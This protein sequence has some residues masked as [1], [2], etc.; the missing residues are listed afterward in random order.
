MTTIR[1]IL[2]VEDSDFLRDALFLSL[3]NAGYQV[4]LAKD[5]EEGVGMARP[6]YDVI[7]MDVGLPKIDGIEAA[8]RIREQLG[9]RC[10]PI[11]AF[12]GLT[13]QY[14]IDRVID[15]GVF[16]KVIFRL[17]TSATSELNSDN[18]W[19]KVTFL[20]QCATL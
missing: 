8:R 18:Y 16:D 3:S 14:D 12:T 4:S 17:I 9:D 2:V 5:G 11:A 20:S 7:L 1:K 19:G 13:A 10:P 15:S 6:I